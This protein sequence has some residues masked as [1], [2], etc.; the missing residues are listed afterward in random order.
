MSGSCCVAHI[1]MHDGPQGDRAVSSTAVQALARYS[2]LQRASV[3]SAL[4]AISHYTSL[5]ASAGPAFVD[6]RNLTKARS[7]ALA[8]LRLAW[9][10]GCT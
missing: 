5:R 7:T 10:C 3:Q 2:L 4:E 9:C 8:A 1:F 6:A